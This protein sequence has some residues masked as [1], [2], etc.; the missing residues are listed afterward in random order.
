M[1]FSHIPACSWCFCSCDTWRKRSASFLTILYRS[2]LSHLVV[3]LLGVLQITQRA[4]TIALAA[5]VTHIT[6][7]P[8]RVPDIPIFGEG[9]NDRCV[10]VLSLSMPPHTPTCHTPTLPESGDSFS[11]FRTAMSDALWH[12]T[13]CMGMFA[14]SDIRIQNLPV[15]V[16][17]SGSAS[18]PCA[19]MRRTRGA[20]STVS[21]AL[22]S[23]VALTGLGVWVWATTSEGG[24]PISIASKRASSARTGCS[25]ALAV[26]TACVV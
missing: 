3:A 21:R 6:R 12:G 22:Q 13:R 26:T 23:R 15:V 20:W 1:V 8:S 18:S 19:R 25:L 4:P 16:L 14:L 24:G 7:T 9:Y 10:N 2:P 11:V 5:P 17:T